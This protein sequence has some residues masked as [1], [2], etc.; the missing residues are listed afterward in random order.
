MP[1]KTIRYR[2]H[3]KYS[4][5]E[6]LT[7]LSSNL[8]KESPDSIESFTKLFDKTLNKHAPFKTIAIRGNNKPHMPKILRKA[9]MLRTR[10][11][12]RSI[13]TR[14]NLDIQ[15]YRQQRNLVVTL[16]KRAMREYY[17]SLDMRVTKDIKSFWK[18]FKPLFSNSMVNEK[19]VLNENDNIIRDAKEISQYFNEYFATIT[20]S[21]NIPKFPTPPIPH[22]G[23]IVC[24]AIQIYASHRSVLNH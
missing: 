4:E 16:N 21:L 17:R 6:F 15:R 22:T 20:D 1:S 11:K 10:L 3:S 2:D 19:I 18:K 13:K 24:D 8:A 23:D 5:V 14:N 7:E 12:N 9:I